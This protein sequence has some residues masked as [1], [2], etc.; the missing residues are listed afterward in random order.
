[1]KPCFM[2]RSRTH[3]RQPAISITWE[4]KW[5]LYLPPLSLIPNTLWRKHV[6]MWLVAGLLLVVSRISVA[7]CRAFTAH[8]REKKQL[9][10]IACDKYQTCL[11]H[12]TAVACVGNR[13]AVLRTRCNQRSNLM[14]LRLHAT[15]I[16]CSCKG[17]RRATFPE[18]WIGLLSVDPLIA[19]D[20]TSY[21]NHCGY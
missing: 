20:L 4:S 10:V 14:Q 3:M 7:C 11:I 9:A 15:E 21:R 2:A 12:A 18:L 6:V 16:A 5:R 13:V 17:L 8:L 19:A 1:M